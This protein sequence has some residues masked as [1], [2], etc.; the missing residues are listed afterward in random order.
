MKVCSLP[1]VG[2]LVW[3]RTDVN[4]IDYVRNWFGA[5]HPAPH[6]SLFNPDLTPEETK[7]EANRQM[8]EVRR[9]L[10][11]LKIQAETEGRRV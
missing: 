4:V 3:W 11:L 8:R 9:R 1:S 10:E 7:V 2:L 5:P 6:A